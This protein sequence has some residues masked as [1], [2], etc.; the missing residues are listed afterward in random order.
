MAIPIDV[1]HKEMII[2]TTAARAV[3][4]KRFL[5]CIRNIDNSILLPLSAVRVEV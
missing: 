2:I 5:V 3:V 4:I 1:N